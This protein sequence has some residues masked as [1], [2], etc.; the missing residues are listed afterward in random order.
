[1]ARLLEEMLRKR[2]FIPEELRS[3]VLA[4][5]IKAKWG[6]GRTREIQSPNGKLDASLRAVI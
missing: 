4:L 1:M 5:H 2:R 3:L 6:F